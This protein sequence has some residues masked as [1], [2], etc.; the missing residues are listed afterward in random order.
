MAS[1]TIWWWDEQA[2]LVFFIMTLSLGEYLNVS[3][4]VPAEVMAEPSQ[5]NA[6]SLSRTHRHIYKYI[7][8]CLPLALLYLLCAG[9]CIQVLICIDGPIRNNALSEVLIVILSINCWLFCFNISRHGF[10]SISRSCHSGSICLFN[11]FAGWP[12][13][14]QGLP[15]RR[16]GCWN[17]SCHNMII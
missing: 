4:A 11:C 10:A 8:I 12:W 16:Y 13:P 5:D 3:R 14:G 9:F 2:C 15:C 1:L 17:K 6:L 7:C